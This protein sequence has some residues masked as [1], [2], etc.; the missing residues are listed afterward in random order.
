MIDE[1]QR[2]KI[3]EQA[4][5]PIPDVST[6]TTEADL[7]ATIAATFPAS[8]PPNFAGGITGV[9]KATDEP[10]VGAHPMGGAEEG[11]EDLAKKLDETIAVVPPPVDED[12]PGD[13]VESPLNP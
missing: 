7:D 10:P 9:P 5:P 11:S 4:E 6:P 12:E 3:G 1:P 8:D 13:A 2:T